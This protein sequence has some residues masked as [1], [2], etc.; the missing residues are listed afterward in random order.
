MAMGLDNEGFS[1]ALVILGAAGLVIPAFARFRI[2]P[3][4]GFIL[5][6][7][8]VGPAGL[9]SLVDRAHW[10]YYITIS[11]PHA[12]EPFAEFGIILLLFSIGPRTLVQTIVDHARAGIRDR[13]L[14]TAR[15]G[16]ADRDRAPFHWAGM[17]RRGG[18]RACPGAVVDCVSAA[19]GGNDERGRA[20]R[21]CDAAVRRSGARPD[22]LRLGCD[23]ADRDSRRVAG[24]CWGRDARGGDG[25]DHVYRRSTGAAPAVRP[26]GADE[27]PRAVPRSLAPRRH[28]RECRDDCGGAVANRRRVAGRSADR[29]NGLSQR[30]RG[31]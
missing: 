27:K 3:V 9:G 24:H 13:R 11:D 14:R 5:V 31:D 18:S 7:L 28:R 21:I 20:R 2:S 10:L 16:G 29:G 12:I 26:G 17:V 15:I 25:R 30:G 22:Y 19:A 8:L 4:I 1:D 6:G 23:G